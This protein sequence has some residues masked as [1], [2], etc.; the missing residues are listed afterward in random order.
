MIKRPFAL[1]GFSF[2]AAMLACNYFSGGAAVA[3]ISSFGILMICLFVKTLDGR[4]VYIAS[5][6]CVLAACV[7]FLT[8][9]GFFYKPALRL[10]GKDRE[11]EAVVVKDTEYS[12]GGKA[13]YL[14]KTDEGEKMRL[15][16]EDND[17]RPGDRISFKCNVFDLT[18]DKASGSYFKSKGVYLGCTS[19]KGLSVVQNRYRF[20]PYAISILRR[21]ISDSVMRFLPNEYGKLTVS[22]LTGNKSGIDPDVKSDFNAVGLSHV[23]AVSGLHMS[24]VVLALF[25]LLRRITGRFRVVRVVICT[26]TALVYA[27]IADF[28]PSAVRAMILVL[29]MLSGYALNKRADTLNS[30]GLA[31]MIITFIN[32]F[33]V[34]DNSFLLSFSAALGLILFADKVTSVIDAWVGKIALRSLAKVLKA[35]LTAASVSIIATVF[36]LPVMIFAIGKVSLLFVPSNVLTF[37]IIP[38]L[39]LFG[40]LT[41]LSGPLGVV[42]AIVPGLCAKYLIFITDRLSRLSFSS[43]SA[44][45]FEIKLWCSLI[46]FFIGVCCLII[47]DKDKAFKICAVFTCFSLLTVSVFKAIDTAG[48]AVFAAIKVD[49]SYCF[50]IKSGKNTV[51]IGTGGPDDH[52]VI[53]SVLNDL[54]VEHVD[55]LLLPQPSEDDLAVVSA[56]T[57]RIAIGTLISPSYSEAAIFADKYEVTDNFGF[58]CGN[59]KGSF[60]AQGV[61][62]SCLFSSDTLNAVFALSEGLTAEFI[63][64]PSQQYDLVFTNSMLTDKRV[65][66]GASAIVCVDDDIPI[67]SSCPCYDLENNS[68]LCIICD[69]HAQWTVQQIC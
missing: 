10:V 39:L 49:S 5:S 66:E 23:L 68:S 58:I 16:S 29:V 44:D 35:V 60:F 12:S 43:V 51:M 30:L 28:T 48:Q 22:L 56:L 40:L 42:F 32:P 6:L 3:I 67:S 57:D 38:V 13:F 61:N 36:C 17:I 2:V 55:L 1:C 18:T 8:Y 31:A 64:D 26:L 9:S 62:R 45:F 7:L 34:A 59:F 4:Q 27:A 24:I 52:T 50:V 37:F 47:A 54:A 46:I 53:S 19:V 65:A 69:R 15:Y 25:S 41:V 14:I 11:I 20:F 21:H 33:S 63:S